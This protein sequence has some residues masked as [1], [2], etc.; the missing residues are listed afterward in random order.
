MNYVACVLGASG[1]VGGWVVHHL[2]ADSNC[3]KIILIGRKKNE[4]LAHIDRVKQYIVNM[5]Q[6]KTESERIFK[7]NPTDVCIITMGCGQASKSSPE[8]LERVDVTLPTEFSI[9]AKN[10]GVRHVSLLTGV[11]ADINAKPSRFTG[12]TA[13]GGLSTHLKGKVEANLTE[14]KF[15]SLSI[16]RPST[17]IGNSNTP[18]FFNWL[19]PNIRWALPTKF[20]DIHID[21]LGLGMV[22]AVRTNLNNEGKKK[23][24]SHNL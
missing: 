11:L 24:R 20:R 16:F 9:A 10:C 6:L 12:T 1:N 18:S 15:P 3:S 7:E 13:I 19:A 23:T 21:D 22:H 2:I 8:E 17:L 14:Q 5:E 4:N